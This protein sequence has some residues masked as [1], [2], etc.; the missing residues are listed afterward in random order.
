M[1]HIRDV[2]TPLATPVQTPQADAARPAPKD[3][4]IEACHTP[5]RPVPSWKAQLA[6]AA[7]EPADRHEASPP[8]A[9]VDDV[10]DP[11]SV[12]S[13]YLETKEQPERSPSGTPHHPRDRELQSLAA[14]FYESSE[15][16]VTQ[17]A[18]VSRYLARLQGH[19]E[20]WQHGE[21]L[22]HDDF[23]RRLFSSLIG[24][25][26]FIHRVGAVS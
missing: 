7:V 13:S 9:E 18:W 21:E 2:I 25:G 19:V 23:I 12:V 24:A 6:A 26:R 17:M 5:Q 1:S 4:E 15:T 10:E 16:L 22:P 11:S 14:G 8:E 3:A 20:G